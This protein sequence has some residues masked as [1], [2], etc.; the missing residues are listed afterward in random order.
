MPLFKK[1]T[2]DAA[3]EMGK[4]FTPFASNMYES[5]I[6]EVK[7]TETQ[8]TNWDTGFPV[9]TDEMV[10][11]VEV[12]FLLLKPVDGDKLL[13]VNGDESEFMNIKFWMDPIK[14]GVGKKG[15]TRGRQFLVAALN[16]KP[17]VELNLAALEKIIVEKQLMNKLIKLI[18]SA[19]T[20]KD[21]LVRNRIEK[22]LPVTAKEEKP[23]K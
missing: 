12:T 5:E 10:D 23:K 4:P 6:V 3:A 7:I 11:Q 19:E 17:D 8:G 1:T 14:L 20:G 18:L 13:T 15:P 22:F 9:K 21:G 2:Y 16:L